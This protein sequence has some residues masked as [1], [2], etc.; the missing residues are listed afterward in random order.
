MRSTSPPESFPAHITA[1]SRI[2]ATLLSHG[3]LPGPSAAIRSFTTA[4][5]THGPGKG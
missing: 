2:A 4:P 3:P 5:S 1:A